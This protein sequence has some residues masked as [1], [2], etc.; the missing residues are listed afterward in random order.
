DLTKAEAAKEYILKEVPNGKLEVVKLDLGDLNGA[1]EFSKL[2]HEKF[3]HVD[4]LINNAGIY[5]FD[6]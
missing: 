6:G 4:V 2:I 3:D 1:R 5:K